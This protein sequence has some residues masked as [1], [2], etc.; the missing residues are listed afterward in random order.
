[1]LRL[2][3][4]GILLL[5]AALVMVVTAPVIALLSLP[6]AA[7]LTFRNNKTAK[8]AKMAASTAKFRR[9][10]VTGGSSGIG[11]AVAEECVKRGFDQVVIVAR[12][13]E[14]LQTAKEALEQL[15][16]STTKNTTTTIAALSVDVSNLQKLQDAAKEIFDKKHI[17]DSS[18]YLFCCAGTA[19]PHYFLDLTEDIILHNTKTN[20]LGATFTV[21]AMLPHMRAGTIVLCSSVSLFS[22]ERLS[23]FVHGCCSHQ[24]LN[25]FF[26]F[27]RWQVK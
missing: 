21:R 2:V 6:A 8:E 22:G 25:L 18:T 1:M 17:E 9:A 20:Q 15:A 14:K 5:P 3:A 27:H 23:I 4:S 26:A 12:N 10:I 24:Q 7:L 13:K 11:L 19:T 16:A